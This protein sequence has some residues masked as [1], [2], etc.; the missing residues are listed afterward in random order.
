MP[1]A[2]D[3]P[4]PRVDVVTLSI[5]RLVTERCIGSF[6]EHWTDRDDY[7]VRW[8]FHQDQYPGL[9]DKWEDNWQAALRVSR[10]FDESQMQA[11]NTNVGL[12]KAYRWAFRQV[13]APMLLIV[14]DDWLWQ[15]DWRLADVNAAANDAFSFCEQR[16]MV[17]GTSPSFWRRYVLNMLLDNYPT[18]EPVRE[19]AFKRI[20]ARKH[21][22]RHGNWGDVPKGCCREI[23]HEVLKEMGF[24]E[25][26]A[27]RKL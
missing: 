26:F 25:N 22:Y 2:T 16:W 14:E 7:F 4:K 9:E 17:G 1:Q 27:G 11:K 19:I 18:E 13:Q 12:G 20:L 23:G 21:H 10:R 15:K 3:Q 5:P 24:T 6:L 8:I